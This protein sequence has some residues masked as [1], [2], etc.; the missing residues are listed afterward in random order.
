MET[1]CRSGLVT[2]GQANRCFYWATAWSRDRSRDSRGSISSSRC[3]CRDSFCAACSSSRSPFVSWRSRDRVEDSRL[4]RPGFSTDNSPAV[5]SCCE[6]RVAG[7]QGFV[8]IPDEPKAS[9]DG[10]IVRVGEPRE[11]IHPVDQRNWALRT[12]PRARQPLELSG[13][14]AYLRARR[15]G[16]PSSTRSSKPIGSSQTRSSPAVSS[17]GHDEPRLSARRSVSFSVR[18]TVRFWPGVDTRRHHESV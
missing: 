15:R 14:S 18:G 11:P 3:S 10:G 8:P 4:E 12:R 5:S 13:G 9:R 6:K 17:G 2:I 16:E 1:A 7:R